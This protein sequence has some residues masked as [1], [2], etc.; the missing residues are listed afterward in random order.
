MC[1]ARS[2]ERRT[3]EYGGSGSDDGGIAAVAAGAPPSACL[4][5]LFWHGTCALGGL[6]SRGLL[7]GSRRGGLCLERGFKGSG[8]RRAGDDLSLAPRLRRSSIKRASWMLAA[9]S[10]V[11]S[12]S[13]QPSQCENFHAL[14]RDARPSLP[15]CSRR[16]SPCPTAAHGGSGSDDGGIAAVAAGAPPSASLLRL[17]WHGTCALGGL[18]SR[19]C[20]AGHVSAGAGHGTGGATV[21]AGAG[22][23]LAFR[24]ARRMRGH[25]ARVSSS[26][27]VQSSS[28]QPFHLTRYSVVGSFPRRSRSSRMASTT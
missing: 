16:Q 10:H 26:S 25:D 23:C 28:G 27:H 3:S 8:E 7:A 1:G 17:F 13:G 5:R 6:R 4:L 19:A 11:L 2:G 12:S 18:R 9:S 15:P 20:G 24:H 14:P 21:V 22:V